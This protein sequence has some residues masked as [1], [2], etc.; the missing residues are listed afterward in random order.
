[1]LPA[2]ISTSFTKF[3]SY[4]Y[5]IVDLGAAF[6]DIITT[7]IRVLF[8]K[9]VLGICFILL[10]V[11]SSK[12]Y[13]HS[14]P[15]AYYGIYFKISINIRAP[16]ALDRV[17]SFEEVPLITYDATSSKCFRNSSLFKTISFFP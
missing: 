5:S 11:A 10:N 15:I 2:V 4:K 16:S 6:K 9:L 8:K 1:M 14:L 13:I 12:R 3:F 7:F 17:Y